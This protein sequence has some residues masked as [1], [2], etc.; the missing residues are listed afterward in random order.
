MHLGFSSMN[1]AD[2]PPPAELA[3]TLEEAGFES[4]WYGEHSHIPVSRRTPYPPGGEL[5]EP[6]KKM[7]DPYLSL[8]AAAAATERL[9]LGTGIAL[10][11][12]R[13]LFSQA[14]TIGTLDRLSNGRL[15]IGCGVGWNEEEF[16]N[17]THLPWKRRYLAIK[18]LVAAQRALFGE[19]E[20]EFHGELIDFDPVWFEP[21]PV[22]R[23]G[24]PVVFG[25]M[26]PLGV[27]HA[28]EWADGWMPVDVAM[29]DVAA[30]V[31]DFRR[32]VSEAGRDPDDVEIT[33]VVMAPVTA[34]LLKSYR[35]LGIQR[36][37]IGV[38]VENWDRPDIVMPMIEEFARLIPQL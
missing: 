15:L 2:D 35:D 27:R 13:E 17:A 21:K 7:M 3:R 19:A 20:P 32:Q 16:E 11:L 22:Q 24:P 31:A 8:M 26:G 10:L 30:G 18:E 12:E 38:G 28:A 36:C 6:Y 14:K 33:L 9:K 34:D 23:G 5:P 1:T 29:P 4:L 25:A 37:N